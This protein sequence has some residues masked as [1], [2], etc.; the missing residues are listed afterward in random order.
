MRE[1]VHFE[2]RPVSPVVSLN[3]K[4]RKEKKEKT[5]ILLKY[6]ELVT[7]NKKKKRK[8]VKSNEKHF[9]VLDHVLLMTEIKPQQKSGSV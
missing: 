9:A 4:K 1:K 8:K 3:L 7:A 5:I 6:D 2:C